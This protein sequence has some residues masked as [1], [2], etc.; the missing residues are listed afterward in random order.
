MT[1]SISIRD[2]IPS[3]ADA[4]SEL[5]SELG[6]RLSP[7]GI[8]Q[9]LDRHN[10]DFSKVFVAIAEGRVA[11]F[12]SFHAIPLLHESS[13]LGRITAMAIH[14]DYQRQGI[15]TSLVQAAE[16]HARSLNCSRLEVT[17]GD[18]REQDAHV[19]Y[20]SLGYRSDCRRFL[21]PLPASA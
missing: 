5:I 3:D 7:P 16:D 1:P 18:H 4:L 11:G 21:K 9:R 12:L 20:T 6:Y 15:G 19:F 14:S 8:V 13:S 10:D 2:A 17:S